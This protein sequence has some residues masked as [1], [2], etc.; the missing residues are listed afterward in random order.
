MSERLTDIEKQLKQAEAELSTARK[1]ETDALEAIERMKREIAIVSVRNA[2]IAAQEKILKDTIRPNIAKAEAKIAELR[3]Q[4]QAEL[5]RIEAQRKAL[6]AER[7]QAKR[8]QLTFGG[9]VPA[10]MF[11]VNREGVQSAVRMEVEPVYF[12]FNPTDYTITQTTRYKGQG[13]DANKNYN[14]EYDSEVEP[15]KLTMSSIWFDTTETGEDVRKQTDKLFAYVEVGSGGGDF[16]RLKTISQKPP[17]T[18]F[19]WGNF[20]F[21]AV[22]ESV[23]LE[24]IHF[25]P[26]GTPLRAKAT[27]SFKEFKHRKLYARQNPTSGANTHNGVWYVSAHE[28]LDTIAMQVYGD[29]TQWRHI[30]AHNQIT[31]PMAI[32]PGQPLVI[33]ALWEV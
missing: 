30:A 8:T 5:E 19:E 23:S 21:L 27:V 24:F 6:E 13:L 16:T 9:L 3:A 28:R 33:P 31:D 32:Y 17:Y 20:R 15:R 7:E 1:Q 18:A 29:A 26:D 14:L 12:R 11:P 25:K 22:V 4:R 10:V 2:T